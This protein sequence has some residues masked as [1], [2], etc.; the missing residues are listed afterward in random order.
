MLDTSIPT[1]Y[2]IQ[3]RVQVWMS[4]PPQRCAEIHSDREQPDE[5]PLVERRAVDARQRVRSLEVVDR[6]RPSEGPVV[7]SVNEN[8]TQR[9]PRRPPGPPLSAAAPGSRRQDD[10][11]DDKEEERK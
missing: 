6:G 8:E 2:V 4:V 1:P 10:D 3:V 9:P 7:G 11:K 5:R